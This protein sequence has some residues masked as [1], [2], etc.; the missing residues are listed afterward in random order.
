MYICYETMY[1]RMYACTYVM[2]MC[3]YVYIQFTES[4]SNMIIQ[5]PVTKKQDP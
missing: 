3:M 1:A 4:R 2:K 5:Y